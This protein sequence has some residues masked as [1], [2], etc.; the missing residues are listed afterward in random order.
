[1]PANPFAPP[2]TFDPAMVSAG[3]RDALAPCRGW[4][5]VSWEWRDQSRD[6][7]WP[8]IGVTLVSPDAA[9]RVRVWFR[10]SVTA[11]ER[12]TEPEAVP[13]RTAM[14][15][16]QSGRTF[17]DFLAEALDDRRLGCEGFLALAV[18]AALTVVAIAFLVAAAVG[19]WR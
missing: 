9:Q 2:T 13:F 6:W 10:P 17:W 11:T 12:L 15:N 4:R 7:S 1:M 14:R 18:I 3:V 16:K 5:F 19:G 8:E